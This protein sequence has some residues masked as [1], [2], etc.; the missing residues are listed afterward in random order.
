MEQLKVFQSRPDGAVAVY[1]IE[2]YGDVREKLDAAI[3][4]KA[5]SLG[6]DGTLLL[7]RKEAVF[8]DNNAT[9]GQLTEHHVQQGSH[10]E[11]L[12]IVLP[13]PAN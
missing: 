4:Q 10:V 5:A 1:D 7:V 8:A 2:A 13:A 11:H 9:T 12:C 3:K 6:C